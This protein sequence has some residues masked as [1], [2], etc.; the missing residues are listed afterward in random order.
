MGT[1]VFA[2]WVNQDEQVGSGGLFERIPIWAGPAKTSMLRGHAKVESPL[3]EPILY[4]SIVRSSDRI[5]CLQVTHRGFPAPA[6]LLTR[7]PNPSQ[8]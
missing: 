7:D 3:G 4:C 8:F 5:S 6:H 1:K 2:P